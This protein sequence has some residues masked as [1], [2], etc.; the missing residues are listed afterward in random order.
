MGARG[1]F[2]WWYESASAEASW[3]SATKSGSRWKAAKAMSSRAS[4][5]SRVRTA[6]KRSYW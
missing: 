6:S 2:A 3:V 1:Y 5:I 4:C